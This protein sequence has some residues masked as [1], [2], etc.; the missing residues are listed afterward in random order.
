MS[1]NSHF[2]SSICIQD[3]LS[4]ERSTRHVLICQVTYTQGVK[5]RSKTIN[6]FSLNL[7][8]G[9]KIAYFWSQN[10]WQ[11]N[12][13]IDMSTSYFPFKDL[14][15]H[16]DFIYFLLW[17]LILFRVSQQDKSLAK[18]S[19]RR[20]GFLQIIQYFQEMMQLHIE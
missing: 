17:S 8:F 7:L 1:Q 6:T 16:V 5:D 12:Q 18:V 9:I 13:G 10:G 11:R 3:Y 14:T 20:W 2:H 15:Q 19:T 4:W